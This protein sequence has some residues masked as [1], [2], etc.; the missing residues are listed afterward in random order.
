MTEA[1]FENS[2]DALD[3]IA[4]QNLANALPKTNETQLVEALIQLELASSKR[5][6]KEFIQNQAISLNGKKITD[7]NYVLSPLDGLFNEYVI[8]RRGKKLYGVITLS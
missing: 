5:E 4:C 2:F 1:L 6:A 7:I 3:K 8:V